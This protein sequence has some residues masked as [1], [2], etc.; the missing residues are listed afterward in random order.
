MNYKKRVILTSL[1]ILL[2]VFFLIQPFGQVYASEINQTKI[3]TETTATEE[4]V[5]PLEFNLN[6]NKNQTNNKTQFAVD[7]MFP[8]DKI[9]HQ[10]NINISCKSSLTLRFKPIIDKNDK[11]SEVLNVRIAYADTNKVLYDGLIKDVPDSF[12]Y[13]IETDKTITKK[14]PY[15]ITTYLDTSVCNEY[16]N[17]GADVVFEWLVNETDA[18][19]DGPK[20]G[21]DFNIALWAGLMLVSMCGVIFLIIKMKKGDKKNDK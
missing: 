18:L 20:T 19:D 8:G 3:A 9:A 15:I 11:L 14:V 10:Y 17:E 1:L 12:D 16:M 6:I 21:D 7:N 13:K 5:K 4:V 2:A